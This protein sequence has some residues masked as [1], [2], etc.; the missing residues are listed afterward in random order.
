MRRKIVKFKQKRKILQYYI[1]EV[2]GKWF[3]EHRYIYE[4]SY[5]KIP[6]GFVIH[7][8]DFNGLNNQLSNLKAMSRDSHN[9]FHSI[10]AATS[11]FKGKHCSLEHKEKLRR[12]LKGR[13]Y[14]TEKN[15]KLA[16]ERMQLYWK[17]LSSEKRQ[18]F[19]QKRQEFL[20]SDKNPY[21]RG[22]KRTPLS[23]KWKKKIGLGNL[24]KKHSEF[25]KRKISES[26]KGH[27]VSE[28]TKNL[29][30]YKS[31]L[32]FGNLKKAKELIKILNIGG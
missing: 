29:L 2:A 19:R 10:I 27:P 13:H 5:G 4:Q 15:K 7:H 16:S 32:Q 1:I 24:N 20:L 18:K 3:Y 8:K 23:D 25:S 26:L 6:T 9:K 17:N 14:Q 30:R 11:G 21:G 28:K 31:Y 12:A 22:K